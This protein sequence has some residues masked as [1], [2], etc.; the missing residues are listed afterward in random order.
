[1]AYLVGEENQFPNAFF[2]ISLQG[3]ACPHTYIQMS[4]FFFK[5]NTFVSFYLSICETWFSKCQRQRG[6][7]A[8]CLLAICLSIS[9]ERSCPSLVFGG[10]IS[11][12]CQNASFHSCLPGSVLGMQLARCEKASW[13][14]TR[15]PQFR[16]F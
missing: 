4:F 12:L 7:A 11:A 9:E 1:M 14:V 10:K 5:S 3:H 15:A 16:S 13:C 2:L 6:R 8:P